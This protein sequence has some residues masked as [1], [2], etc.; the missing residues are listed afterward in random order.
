MENPQI[1]TMSDT[2]DSK[3]GCVGFIP[4]LPGKH[5]C[6]GCLSLGACLLVETTP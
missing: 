3:A 4:V 2:H 6:I 1:G 5:T